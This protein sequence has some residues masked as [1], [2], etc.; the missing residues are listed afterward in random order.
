MSGFAQITVYIDAPQA[1]A[2]CYHNNMDSVVTYTD[3]LS[4]AP[5]LMH[6][7]TGQMQ[8]G[9]DGIIVYDGLDQSAPI[10]FSG[11]N[12]GDLAGLT[13]VS[14]NADNALT[15]RIQS[16]AAISC[17]DQPYAHLNWSVASAVISPCNLA[18]E[19]H[20][21]ETFDVFPNPADE[22]LY[23]RFPHCSNVGS[24]IEIFDITGRIVLI[25]QY[26]SAGTVERTFDLHALDVGNYTLVLSTTEQVI[27]RQFQ[28]AR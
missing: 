7:C 12:L 28:I 21:D 27:A 20:T 18:I 9:Y 2:T 8:Y 10:L 19:E 5:L 4:S 22:M 13:F 6:F 26:R 14:T 1:F 15:L 23:L 16:N 25:E 11:S 17:L 3:T 24:R